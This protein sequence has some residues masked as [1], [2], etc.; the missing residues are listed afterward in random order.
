MFKRMFTI[1]RGKPA[2]GLEPVHGVG[3]GGGLYVSNANVTV[4]YRRGEQPAA[5]PASAAA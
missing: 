1:W 5:A 3:E 2:E 4:G